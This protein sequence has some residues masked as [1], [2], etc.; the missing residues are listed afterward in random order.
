MATIGS[1][2]SIYF[3]PSIQRAITVFMLYCQ[4]RMESRC[5]WFA[6]TTQSSRRHPP[7]H[8]CL[9][10]GATITCYRVCRMAAATMQ[11]CLLLAASF[12]ESLWMAVS[13]KFSLPVSVIFL[14]HPSIMMANF[15]LTTLTWNMTSIRHGIGRLASTM[16]SVV[17]S[18]AGETEQA[19]ILNSTPTIC[20]PH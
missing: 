6:A 3:E 15:L 19:S 1:T 16:S 9:K 10:S 2:K 17:Q 14:M 7:V 8:R 4:H 5:I 12:I 18:L 13:L 11:A 20:Q